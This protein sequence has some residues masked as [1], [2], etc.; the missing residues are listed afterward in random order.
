MN[1]FDVVPANFFSIL[2][3]KNK[4]IYYDCLKRIYDLYDKKMGFDVT[5]NEAME[6]LVDY[7]DMSPD[8]QEDDEVT[9]TSREKANYVINR[10]AQTGWLVLETDNNY[11][12]LVSFRYYAL[13][14]LEGFDRIA[15][16]KEEDE[17]DYTVFE[18]KGYLFSIYSLLTKSSNEEMNIVLNQVARL[19]LEFIGELKKINLKL[20]DNRCGHEYVQSTRDALRT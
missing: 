1:I 2:A 14:V 8:F 6:E 5:R 9:Q 11:N 7:F 19:S 20:R 4:C 17:N 13:T 15:T 12:D 10:L 16:P 3:S 18:Y